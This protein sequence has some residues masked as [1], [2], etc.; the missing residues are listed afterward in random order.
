MAPVDS[1][2][3]ADAWICRAGP[4]PGGKEQFV[5]LTPW[6]QVGNSEIN[7]LVVSS[8]RKCGK[9]NKDCFWS[10]LFNLS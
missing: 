1:R 2:E 3:K 8:R 4:R 5:S 7:S 9:T 6:M 10:V